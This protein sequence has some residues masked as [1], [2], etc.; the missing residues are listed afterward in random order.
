VG[1]TDLIDTAVGEGCW[2]DDQGDSKLLK[3]N[4]VLSRLLVSL[5]ADQLQDLQND[6]LSNL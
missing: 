1:E 5:A 6:I 3:S 4:R 2:W